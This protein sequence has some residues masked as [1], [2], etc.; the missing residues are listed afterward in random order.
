MSMLSEMQNVE[1]QPFALENYMYLTQQDTPEIDADWKKPFLEK[2]DDEINPEMSYESNAPILETIAKVLGAET[3]QQVREIMSEN[4][5]R[6]ERELDNYDKLTTQIDNLYN[7]DNITLSEVRRVAE[8]VVNAISDEITKLQKD[9]EEKNRTFPELKTKLDF[10]KCSRKQIVEAVG[11]DTLLEYAKKLFDP[12]RFDDIDLSW[13]A[14]DIIDNWDAILEL[15]SDVFILNEGFGIAKNFDNDRHE[16]TGEKEVSLGS[17]MYGDSDAAP[18]DMDAVKEQGSEQQSWQVDSRTIDIVNELISNPLVKRLLHDCYVKDENGNIVLSKWGIPERVQVRDA[19]NSILHWTQGS[20]S[21]EDMITK[22][23]AKVSANRWL[24]TLI[25][26]LK[27]PDETHLQSQFLTV[28]WKP[29][30]LFSVVTYDENKKKYVPKV[31]NSHPAFKEIMRRIEVDFQ[32]A[33]HPLFTGFGESVRVNMDYLGVVENDDALLD[34][35]KPINLRRASAHIMEISRKINNK[36][37]KEGFT[38]EFVNQAVPYFTAACR[39][40][41]FYADENL[42]KSALAE[43]TV[44]EKTGLKQCNMEAFKQM[45]DSLYKIIE[46]LDN[47]VAKEKEEQEHPTPGYTGYKPFEF[48]G[49]NNIRSSLTKLITPVTNQLEDTHNSSVYDSGKM[50]QSYVTPSF[51]TLLMNKLKDSKVR[52]GGREQEFITDFYGKSE[53]FGI[54][55]NRGEITWR[56]EMLREL[57]LNPTAREKFAHKVQLNFNKHNFM[58]NMSP[59]EYTLSLITEYFAEGNDVD[60]KG[61]ALSWYKIPMESNKPS[62]EFIRFWSYRSEDTY[63]TNVVRDLAKMFLQELS[64]IQ[65]VRMRNKNKGDAGF[66]E[67]WDVNGRMFCFL[68]CFNDYLIKPGDTVKGSFLQNTEGFTAED[69]KLLAQEISKRLNGEAIDIDHELE[70]DKNGK[71]TRFMVMVKAALKTFMEQRTNQILA[72]WEKEGILAEAK[73]IE[74]VRDVRKDVENYIWNNFLMAKNILQLTVGDI[75]FYKDAEDLQK[76]LAELHAPG[77]RGNKYARYKG[78]RVSDGFYRTAI[79]RD[80]RKQTNFK[81]NLIANLTEVLDR[82][83]ESAHTEEDEEGWKVLKDSL[84]GEHGVYRDVNVTDAQAYSSPTS[85]RKKAIIFGK[86]SKEAEEVYEKVVN[87]DAT[88][89]EVRMAFQPLKPFVYGFLEKNLGVDDAPIQTMHEPFQAKNSE[90]LLIMADALLQNEKTSQPNLLRAIYQV[91]EDSYYVGRKRDADGKIIEKGVY[92]GRGIDTI[93]FESSIKSALQ[94]TVDIAQHWD[95]IDGEAKAIKMLEDAIYKKDAQGNRLNE[96]NEDTFVQ[97]TDYDNYCIQ[98]EVPEHF[99]DHEQAHG[100]QIRMITPSDLDFYYDPNGDLSAE[101]NIVKYEVEVFDKSKNKFVTKRLNADEFR[102][103]YEGTIAENINYSCGRLIKELH[104]EGTKK[105][106]NLALSKIL[107][108]EILSSPRYGIDLLLACTVDKDG[109]FR[110]PKGD[111]IQAKRIEQLCN[112]IIKN[113]L[114]KQKI[115][116]GPIVQVTNFGTDRLSVV[117]KNKVDGGVLLTETEWNRMA[118]SNEEMPKDANGVAF[119]TYEDYIHGRQGGIAYFECFAPAWTKDIFAKFT[120]SDGTIDIETIEKLDPDLL[121][122]VGYRIPTED[123]YSCAPLKIKGFLPKIAGEAI[124][125]PYELTTIND[126]DFDVDKEYVMRKVIRIEVKKKDQIVNAMWKNLKSQEDV[127]GYIEQFVDNPE[128]FKDDMDLYNRLWDEYIKVAYYTV[129]PKRGPE[130]RNNKIV[131]M[132]YEVLSH[133]TNVMKI[134]NPGGFDNLKKPA[135]LIEAFRLNINNEEYYLTEKEKDAIQKRVIEESSHRL[136]SNALMGEIVKELNKAHHKKLFDALSSMPTDEL[137]KLCATSKDLAWP[138]TEIQFYRQNSAAASLISV[139]AVNK[140]AHATLEGNGFYI[141][142]D[143]LCAGESFTINGMTFGGMMEIDKTY[144]R[145]GK[146]IGKLLGST[147]SAS[148]DAVKDPIFN[149]VNVNMSTVNLMNTLIRFGMPEHDV[150]MFMAQ[151][152]ISRAVDEY[153]KANLTGKA[154]FAGIVSSMMDQI[155]KKYAENLPSDSQLFTEELTYDEMIEGILPGRHPEIDL[156]VLNMVQKLL[157]ISDVMRKLDYPT[158]FNSVTNAAGP[159]VIDNLITE[160]NIKKFTLAGAGKEG[161]HI[162]TKYTEDEL[163]DDDRRILADRSTPANHPLRLGFKEADINTVLDKH[164]VLAGFKRG[165]DIA[166]ELFKDMPAG[167]EG[168]RKLLDGLPDDVAESFFTDKKLLDRLSNFY[169]TYMLVAAGLLNPTKK[170]R[171]G[172]TELESYIL[173]FPV[174]FRKLLNSEEYVKELD[175]DNNPLIRAIQPEIDPNSGNPYLKIDLTGLDPQMKQPMIDGWVDLYKSGVKGKDLATRLMIYNIYRGGIGFSPKTFTALISTYLKERFSGKDRNGNDVMYRDIFELENFPKMDMEVVH[176]DNLSILTVYDQFVRNNWDDYRLVA[177][178]EKTDKFGIDYSK[179]ELTVFSRRELN[180][181]VDDFEVQRLKSKRYISTSKWTQTKDENGKPKSVKTTVLWRQKFVSDDV[182]VYEEVKPLGNNGEYFEMDIDD[183]KTP[184]SETADM[185]RQDISSTL[186]D[187]SQAEID[188][189]SAQQSEA[190]ANARAEKKLATV[191]EK[192]IAQLVENTKDLRIPHTLESA[193][194]KLMEIKRKANA[195]EAN[196]FVG[197]L[198]DLLE[199][200]GI[201]VDKKDTLEEFLKYC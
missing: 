104:L 131:D 156:K 18:V 87:G 164:P 186:R 171:S 101:A 136:D 130:Y 149:L 173:G 183:I 137:K 129:H 153:N 72:K 103:E 73:K 161:T 185:V 93:Q 4:Q 160:H 98:Q 63:K 195:G 15:G 142:V 167:S 194:K 60:N 61:R 117:Y 96:Y 23:E 16:T 86:W 169:Q 133:E 3:K 144:N 181:T 135:Y 37:N 154:S 33:V 150:F 176:E 17:E 12:N 145:E 58:R 127:A 108:R 66:V 152:V 50:Y 32:T 119:K 120:K 43:T 81:S 157:E 57:C 77:I 180:G 94:G 113:R 174:Y 128:S 40:L 62:A 114:N 27:N 51:M 105:E 11:I 143:G 192:L 30:Q 191:K 9:A 175:L 102:K 110:I 41:G 116:G 55:N 2:L 7:S 112:S 6:Q 132:T 22:L 29:Y 44:D 91:M 70:V 82:K 166:A 76:R 14:W 64:R 74:H 177:Y 141:D 67:N 42:V 53:W 56:N 84:V 189:A 89:A 78:V 155:K 69:D 80:L 179:G 85:Y 188:Q 13:Q 99:A 25:Q 39:T 20:Q 190:L 165:I 163:T 193:E 83:I 35:S 198:H 151:D 168:F 124:M 31:V 26:T 200:V 10:T 65:T 140:V 182:L 1:E 122:M 36:D 59:Q 148:A 162:F 139:Q 19:V 201:K 134:L 48:K 34:S 111:P 79:L 49:E 52:E 109:N 187:L 158:R 92:T 46:E 121:K 123:K 100:S 125:L 184:M 54:M 146:L 126:S 138:D 199:Q 68:P 47:A 45:R 88:L 115:A 118:S 28:F 5:R 8:Q 97:K 38:M 147:V 178:Q 197:F 170:S 95:D 21:L 106:R 107:R 71:D 75:A 159:L 172:R 196:H 90:Y 24:E